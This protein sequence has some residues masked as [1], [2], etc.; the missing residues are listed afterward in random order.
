[1]FK[2][3]ANAV[4]ASDEMDGRMFRGRKI[5]VEIAA[6]QE[7]PFYSRNV[8]YLQPGEGYQA[9]YNR[10]FQN[11]QNLPLMI[12][13]NLRGKYN[14]PQAFPDVNSGLFVPT[15]QMHDMTSVNFMPNTTFFY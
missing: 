12:P 7:K 5:T 10:S 9:T 8:D 4:L 15:N 11:E 13:A 6:H 2:K 1:V 3:S 14:F